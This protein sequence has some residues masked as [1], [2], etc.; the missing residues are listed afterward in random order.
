MVEPAVNPWCCVWPQFDV[1]G[2]VRNR[3]KGDE[4]K[5]SSLVNT[6]IKVGFKYKQMINELRTGKLSSVPTSVGV[7][8]KQSLKAAT[9]A[10]QDADLCIPPKHA[11]RQEPLTAAKVRATVC[12][13]AMKVPRPLTPWP[14]CA[15]SAAGTL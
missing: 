15:P 8:L 12:V 5:F 14:M 11:D 13:A 2:A 1:V 10:L 3:A 6:L 4:E 7:P 9:A